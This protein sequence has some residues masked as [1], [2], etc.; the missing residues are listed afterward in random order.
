MKVLILG[1][2]ASK[3]AG[4]PVAAELM[5][6]IE[7]DAKRSGN[8]VLRDAWQHWEETKNKAPGALRLLLDDPNPEVVISV[9]DLCGMSYFAK[10]ER[11]VR[12][13][14]LDEFLSRAISDGKIPDDWFTSPNAKWLYDADTA[15]FRLLD[16][17]IAYFDWKHYEDWS[18]SP[19][20]REYLRRE[21][22]KLR[23]GDVVITTNW[24]TGGERTLFEAGLWSPRDGY[25]F[26]RDL[27]G[28]SDQPVGGVFA[29]PSK[30]LV[31]KL[32]GSVGWYR[33]GDEIYLANDFLQRFAGPDEEAVYDPAALR[34]GAKPDYDPV[35]AYPSFLKKL[36]GSA[37]LN[38]WQFA[39]AALRQTD[40]IEVW[41]YSLP[42]SD[43]AIRALM[44]PLRERLQKG[45][46]R[47]YVHV[48]FDDVE[49][50]KTRWRWKIFLPGAQ[51]DKAKLG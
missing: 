50:K 35:I 27:R 25:G 44:N 48:P 12:A 49:A 7:V 40:E 18:S 15:R 21:L 5:P 22:T 3:E 8:A 10:P 1:A 41:G 43:S 11:A 23:P 28:E 6:T 24:D 33:S 34:R 47:V 29:N 32:H 26:T 39:D 38:I 31:L 45:Q 36:D 46:V 19:D 37:I 13:D 4:Y 20:R 2:G 30:I 9:L 14:R 51:V 42:P 17:L 16:C